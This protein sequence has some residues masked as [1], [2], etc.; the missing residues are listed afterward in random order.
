MRRFRGGPVKRTFLVWIPLALFGV[1]TLFPIYWM[2][3]TSLLSDSLSQQ[4][5]LRYLPWPI[6]LENY[7]AAW[8]SLSIGRLVLNSLYVS[9]GSGLLALLLASLSAYAL[10]RF[11]FRAKGATIL[12]LAMT[13]MIPMVLIII[14]TFVVFT[15]LGLVNSLTGLVLAE[16]FLAAAFA[17]LLLRQFYDQIPA[18]IDEAAMVDGCTRI[19]ALFR[20]VMP[21]AIPGMVAVS[22]FNF[23]NSWNSLLLPTVMLNDPS[24]FT[25]SPGLLTMKDQFVFS[26]GLQAT[27]AVI[28]IIP[29]LIFF[30]LVQRF[31]IGGI[32]AGSV[33]G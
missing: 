17:T 28:A 9:L 15:K 10:S 2:T 8:N 13:Q 21:L 33:K 7:V 5:P 27:G 25:L 6:T 1:W 19:G 3:R 11:R 14:P 20:V 26:W 24:K 12:A 4:L 32:A 23:I 30:A 29:S 16:G 18:Q 22:V 31:L